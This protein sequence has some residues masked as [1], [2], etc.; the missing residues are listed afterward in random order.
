MAI[1]G[2]VPA[3]IAAG[4]QFLG[5]IWQNAQQRSSAREQMRF[6]ER[7]SSTAHQREV[8]DLRKAGLNPVLSFGG[9]GASA[10][11]GAQANIGDAVGPAVSSAKESS[12][13]A[14][15]LQLMGAQYADTNASAALKGAQISETNARTAESMARTISTIAGGELSSAR[16]VSERYK[17]EQERGQA[18]LAN[19]SPSL[20]LILEAIRSLK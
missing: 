19:I 16:T 6:Q 12:L 3:I 4:S 5:G 7:M 17:A 1:P 9:P 20:R 14:K 13:A 10:P 2:L 18:Q 11:G 15:Q 8:A